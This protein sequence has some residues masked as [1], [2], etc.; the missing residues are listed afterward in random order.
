MK[1]TALCLAAIITVMSVSACSDTTKGDSLLAE[2][3]MSATV[4]QSTE[5]GV[6]SQNPI[7]E[8]D[9]NTLL[10]GRSQIITVIEYDTLPFDTENKTTVND[11]DYY[12]VTDEKYDDWN[13]WTAYVKSIYCDEIAE[14]ILNDNKII[15]IDGKTYTNDGGKGNSISNEYTYSIIS[16]TNDTITIF[17]ENIDNFTSETIETE[18]IFENTV[19]GWRIKNY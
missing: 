10:Q 15:N 16:E 9:I 18:I 8:D 14:T 1:K 5:S 2:S 4:S 3:T 17:L 11:I 19:N 12:R 7:S 13:E 6:T